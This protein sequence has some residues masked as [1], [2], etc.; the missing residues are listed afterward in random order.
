MFSNAKLKQTGFKDTILKKAGLLYFEARWFTIKARY[1]TIQFI[2]LETFEV[3]VNILL[4]ILCCCCCF[5]KQEMHKASKK[6]E[7]NYYSTSIL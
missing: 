4:T 7:K 3:L 2:F 5:D 6:P 1:G